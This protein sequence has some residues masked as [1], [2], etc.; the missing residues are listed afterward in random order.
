VIDA[1]VIFKK[2][3]YRQT[4]AA[5]WQWKR[6][7]LQNLCWTLWGYVKFTTRSSKKHLF[8]TDSKNCKICTVSDHEKFCVHID[9]VRV[10]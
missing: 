3:G 1:A 2:L 8:I 6:N 5:K 9:A 10:I 7:D 4:L